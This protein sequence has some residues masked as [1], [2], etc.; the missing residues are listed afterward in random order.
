MTNTKTL[1]QL[2][3][4]L[5]NFLLG[6]DED[7]SDLTLET[8]QF[9]RQERLQIYHSAYRLRLIEALGT[10]YPALQAYVGEKEFTA[11]AEGFIAAHPS[12]NPSLRWLGE[13]LPAFLRNHEKF[14]T[15]IEMAE[16]AEFEWRQAMAFDAADTSITTLEELRTLVPEQWMTLK[17][18]L[19]PSV[20]FMHFYSN[21]PTLWQTL[22]HDGKLSAAES[23]QAPQAWLL[24]REDL[25]VVF[26]P[27]DA[28]EDWALTAFSTGKKFAEVCEGLCEW[29][30]AQEVPMKAAQYLQH[31]IQG[32][33]IEAIETQ[34]A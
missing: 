8:P 29:F 31:W 23:A 12:H 28:A 19:H 9:S 24:W 17:L 34:T 6:N 25:Q 1:A 15:Q 5:Q 33:L 13:K 2:Q 32:S 16:L 27:L 18:H 22:I 3:L 11:I 20:Q 30:S 4:E 26:R 21:A 7:A 10:D 14:N